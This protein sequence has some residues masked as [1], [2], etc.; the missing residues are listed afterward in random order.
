MHHTYGALQ[1]R[2]LAT[3]TTEAWTTNPA[4]QMRARKVQKGYGQCPVGRCQP[5]FCW[6]VKTTPNEV[7]T[8][9]GHWFESGKLH[10]N[11]DRH[12]Y[13]LIFPIAFEI[14][15]DLN[16]PSSPPI[17]P[18]ITHLHLI[19]TYVNTINFCFVCTFL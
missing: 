11:F 8:L 6:A 16:Q 10:P 3:T 14:L 9:K 12:F 7:R 5:P 19:S 13:M 1:D 15:A 17:P 2:E 4:I 18:H